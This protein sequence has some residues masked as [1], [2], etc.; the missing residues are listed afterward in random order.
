MGKFILI[1]GPSGSGKGTVLDY[2]KKKHPEFVFPV[3]CTT[4]NMRPGE[5]NGEVY[6]FVTPEEFKARIDGG[7]FLEYACVHNDNYYGT[8]K[9]PIMEALECGKKVVRE[10]DVQ[11]V[12]SIREM[13]DRGIVV[14]IFLK[15]DWE[16]LRNRILKRAPI[17]EH[18]LAE[19]RISFDKEM[20]WENEC[21]FVVE[22]FENRIDE[23]CRKIEEIIL[24]R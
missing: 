20:L 22:S 14:T 7:E 19:R 12:R 4:R 6:F 23:V 24:S 1:L 5:K 8:L 15:A 9:A 18:E 16:H 10:V 3:S 2:L 21:D 13:F 11:G 17:S